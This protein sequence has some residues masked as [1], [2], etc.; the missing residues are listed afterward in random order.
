MPIVTLGPGFVFLL[1]PP[2]Q[3]TKDNYCYSFLDTLLFLC[4]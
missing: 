4:T 1:L 2:F 3:I